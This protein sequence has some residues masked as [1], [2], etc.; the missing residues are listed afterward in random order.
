MAAGSEQ[1]LAL[2]HAQG[3]ALRSTLGN[4]DMEGQRLTDPEQAALA[5]F[6]AGQI[7]SEQYLARLLPEYYP[8]R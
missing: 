2:T 8:A 1:T 5:E 4:M 6:I 3:A 7:T